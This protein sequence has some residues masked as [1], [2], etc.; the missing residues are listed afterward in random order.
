MG[1]RIKTGAGAAA[2]V[3]ILCAAAFIALAAVWIRETYGVLSIAVA[4]ESFRNMLQNKRTLFAEYVVIPTAAIF[5]VICM[6][7]LVWKKINRRWM[8]C[9]SAVL[10][11]VSVCGAVAELDAVS[12]LARMHRLSREQWYDV[13][14][15]VMHA[16]GAV[17]GDTYT[18]AKEALERSY[19]DGNRVMECDFAL[20]SDGQI[21]ACHDWEVW[22]R[23]T[24]PDAATEEDYVPSLAV[25]MQCRIMG[26]YTPLSGDDIV[27]FMKEHPDLYII[28]DTKEADPDKIIEGF[29]A[30][31]DAAVRNEC[32]E[33]LDRMVVQIYHGYMYDLVNDIYPFPHYIYTLY[34]E[35]YRGEADK[36]REYAKYCVLHNIDV[37]TMNAAC[38]QEELLEICNRYG[39]RLFVHTVNE[40]DEIASFTGSG[41]GVYTDNL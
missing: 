11:L 14:D 10:L 3:M 18:N 12:C 28:T 34:Q 13:N 15:M 4:D 37:I 6:I 36:M 5:V 8:T 1:A 23:K 27:L 16:L 40:K 20:T 31:V 2:W 26:K 9:I 19:R 17:D 30:L 7:H 29:T 32:E 38:Y 21:V 39:L 25:F 35:G 33:T 22:N 41:I 24:N